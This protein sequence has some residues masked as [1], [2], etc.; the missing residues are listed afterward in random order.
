MTTFLTSNS[1]QHNRRCNTLTVLVPLLSEQIF[2]FACYK[3]S[4]CIKTTLTFEVEKINSSSKALEKTHIDEDPRGV[5]LY[6]ACVLG[7]VVGVVPFVGR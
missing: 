2:Y 6:V 1:L 5:E 7:A 3:Q 4:Q